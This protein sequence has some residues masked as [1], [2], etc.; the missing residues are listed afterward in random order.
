MRDAAGKAHGV[1][2]P[3]GQLIGVEVTSIYC[4]CSA[5]LSWRAAR[6]Q[7]ICVNRSGENPT[8]ER[9]RPSHR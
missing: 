9:G 7:A 3:L 2:A 8:A 1:A 5:S 6:T 4:P